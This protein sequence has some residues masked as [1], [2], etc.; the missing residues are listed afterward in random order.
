MLLLIS[1]SLC[2]EQGW[3]FCC[4]RHR[5]M[6]QSGVPVCAVY[7]PCCEDKICLRNHIV[8]GAGHAHNCLVE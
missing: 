8:G 2:S 5:E 3:V 7:Y 4:D 6:S 1:L